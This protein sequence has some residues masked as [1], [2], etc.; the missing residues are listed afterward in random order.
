MV[1]EDELIWADLAILA[2]A[3]K[4]FLNPVLDGTAAR[5]WT[6]STWRWEP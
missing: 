1:E 3:V 4:A 6:P 2:R 5:T